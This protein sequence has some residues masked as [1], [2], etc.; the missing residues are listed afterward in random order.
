MNTAKLINENPAILRLK[1]LQVLSELARKPG[2]NTIVI[3]QPFIE[4]RKG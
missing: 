3:G 4:A 1:E 2:N